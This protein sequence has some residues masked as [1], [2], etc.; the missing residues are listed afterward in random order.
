MKLRTAAGAVSR[1]PT[2]SGATTDHG[3]SLTAKSGLPS[4]LTLVV[5]LGR[6]VGG[7]PVDQIVPP[8]V[9]TVLHGDVLPGAP[10][11]KAPLDRRRLGHGDVGA[12]LEWDHLSAP[13]GAVGRDEE[14]R[15]GVV[16][17]ITERLGR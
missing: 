3:R 1:M 14:P 13:P 15:L 17:A 5:R 7:L 11:H 6:A 16:D 4:Y 12:L 8:D 2:P 10:H 9:P